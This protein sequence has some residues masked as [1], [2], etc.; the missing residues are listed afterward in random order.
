MRVLLPLSVCAAALAAG[1]AAASALGRS[2]APVT[3]KATVG[4]GYAISLTQSGRKVRTLKPGSYRIVVSDR[5]RYHDFTLEQE[6]G[7]TFERHLTS[8]AFTGAKT[9]TLTLKAG[10][11]KFY[12]SAHE[13][14]MSG[15]VNVGAGAAP[16]PPAPATTTT[17]DGYGSGYGDG[18]AGYGAGS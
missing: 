7:G 12:C 10:R 2:A 18:G 9:V 3:L 11:W 17:D 15:L 5:S 1:F 16:P 4:P 6:S 13:P 14:Q 8:V